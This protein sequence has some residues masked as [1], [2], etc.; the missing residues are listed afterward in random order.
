MPPG[1]TR[2][3]PEPETDS[4]GND[5]EDYEGTLFE[6]LASDSYIQVYRKN[7][8]TKS[9]VYTQCR[10]DPDA[11]MEDISRELGGGT[12][13]LRERKRDPDTGRWG[14]GM[15]RV[16][17]V[18]GSPKVYVPP[19]SPTELAVPGSAA[20][21]SE[22]GGG[23]QS[24]GFNDIMTGGLLNMFTTM[25]K[26]GE[27]QMLAMQKMMDRPRTD[28]GP[29][30]VALAPVFQAVVQRANQPEK[31]PI[32]VLEVMEKVLP[33]VQQPTPTTGFKDMIETMT[34]LEGFKQTLSEGGGGGDDADPVKIA[35]ANVP[36]L[37]QII[38]NEQA[39][40][41]GVMPTAKQLQEAVQRDALPAG[42]GGLDKAK[43]WLKQF[44]L[45]MI[46]WAQEA[47]DPEAMAESTLDLIPTQF[48]GTLSEFLGRED[49]EQLVYEVV[50]QLGPY[51]QWTTDFFNALHAE[52]YPDEEEESE[53]PDDGLPGDALPGRIDDTPERPMG[54][55]E[56][57]GAPI[58]GTISPDTPG[59]SDAPGS[60]APG[61][62]ADDTPD[63]MGVPDV[64]DDG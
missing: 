29:I 2:K 55:G 34:A 51:K 54:S 46:R 36:R 14:I 33:L 3:P 16:V 20:P 49:A 19:S 13:S 64:Q 5:V 61:G 18:E 26:A 24:I 42:D 32:N 40:R 9:Y 8:R 56:N 23:S 47:K 35:M 48:H 22:S 28:W 11:S 15:Q 21:T 57:V 38:E 44:S 45:T 30:F 4:V 31:E 25:G 1:R 37:L 10:L 17:E 41:K 50:P 27:M 63:S 6:N 53:A 62:T 52:F 43:R 12:F 59:G 7:E 58:A 39:A 60:D